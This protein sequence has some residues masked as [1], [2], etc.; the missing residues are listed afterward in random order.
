MPFQQLTEEACCHPAIASRL[1]QDVDDVA[2]LVHGATELLPALNRHEELVQIPG[3]ARPAPSAPQRPRVGEAE[4]LTPM[5]NRFIRHR[6]TS[7]GEEIFDISETQAEAMIDPDGVTNDLGGK[8]VAAV[9]GHRS[10][11]PAAASA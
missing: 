5:P 7:L 11:L 3:V 8:A 4:R 6:D 2:I 9:A 10:T 1:D